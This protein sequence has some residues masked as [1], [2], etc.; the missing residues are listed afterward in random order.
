MKHKQTRESAAAILAA[1]CLLLAGAFAPAPRA[2]WWCTAF[3]VTGGETAPQRG[4][5]QIELRFA[6]ADWL[7]ALL[8]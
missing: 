2:A 6:L 4:A 7:H 3:S 1:V 8:G 5:A